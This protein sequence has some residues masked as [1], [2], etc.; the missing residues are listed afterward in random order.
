MRAKSGMIAA[1]LAGSMVGASPVP[2]WAQT[3]SQA[4]PVYE[5]N[6]PAQDLS[7]ALRAVVRRAGLELYATS[8][9]VNG[10]R[11]PGLNGKMSVREALDILLEGTGLE[12]EISDGAVL[13]MG[14]GQ[15]R[16]AEAGEVS[17][18]QIV[19]TGTH[20]R[21][22][23]PVAP[24]RTA[25][26]EDIEEQGHSDLG[27]FIRSIPENYTGG[28]NPTVAGG[29]SQ[30]V[31]NENSS[32][33]SALNLRGLGPAATLTLLNGHRMAYDTV[34]QGVDIS[35][36]PLA[37]IDRIE[38]VTDGSSAL[39][40]SD[41]VGGVAN[42][43]LRRDYEGAYVSARLGGSSDGGNFQQQYDALTGSRWDSGGVMVA[44]SFSDVTEI[45]ARDRSYTRSLDDSTTL[46]PWR[47]QYSLI[48]AGHQNLT[49]RLGLEFDAQY[50]KRVTQL[51]QPFTTTADVTTNGLQS[52][53]KV[54]SATV[55]AG[56]HWDL[57]HAWTVSV[58]GVYGFS[59]NHITS[60]RYIG[61]AETLRTRLN[62]DN[63]VAT[64][65]VAAEGPLLDLPGGE[66]RLALGAGYR[67]MGLDVFVRQET[68][69]T[70]NITKDIRSGRE[71]WF[72]YGELSLP[73]VGKANRM[74]LIERLQLSLAARYEDYPGTAHLLTP[75]AGVVYEPIEGLT[76]RGAWG[77]SFKT[78]TLYQQY[79]YR[80]GSL[81][82]AA[83][84]PGSPTNLP[85]LLVAGGNINLKPE[86]AT[87]WNLGFKLV[88]KA[89]DGFE[90]EAT[91]FD[92]RYRDR[93]VSPVSSVLAIYT[94]PVYADYV[95]L[96]PSTAQVL[97]AIADLPQGLNNQT[98]EPFDPSAVGALV[99]AS[100]QNAARQHLRG[101]D[102]AARYRIELAEDETLKLEGSA[103]YLKSDQRL[104]AGYPLEELAGTIFDPPHWRGRLGATWRKDN[105]TLSAFGS[106][107]GGVT[108]DRFSPIEHV[109]SFTTLD[110]V[111]HL[112]SQAQSGIG[113]GVDLT[114][115]I[116]NLFNEKPD[117]IQNTIPVYPPY[118]S[119][120]YSSIGRVI[121]IAVS[122]AL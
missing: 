40:G 102:L 5:F 75:K 23:I 93:V 99:D 9:D 33:S 84:F 13:I 90:F 37:A 1:L 3:K 106:Y 27:D 63:D 78:Q 98:G 45:S 64:G 66:A 61:G 22:A 17:D 69:G 108:D 117:T 51:S 87:T 53:P 18:K 82:P 57:G 110:F 42:V 100:F 28:Q 46:V 30:G 60:H 38:I 111:G 121:T 71:V 96:N 72:G 44:G 47:R 73:L 43:I 41:A 97:A 68:S 83:Y 56:L 11:A 89:L 19:V 59:S 85:V 36:I 58:T 48:A 88:P 2:A 20:I 10:V 95:T 7:D 24:V 12:A 55:S 4:A 113:Q 34:S 119:T 109:K 52:R 50:N 103:S 8:S 105:V 67:H 94:N 16:G 29:G 116:Q 107:I 91:W 35:Q 77:K 49:D 114:V 118:D 31:D 21:G 54:Q 81:N 62:Y 79:Q 115:S 80:Q 6:L 92:I 14:P 101:L 65:E 104:S 32:S 39:Y 15:R 26:R 76:L 86:K 70:S 120:N 112:R 25:S 74:P 122:K